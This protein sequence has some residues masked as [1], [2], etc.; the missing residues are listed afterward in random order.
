MIVSVCQTVFEMDGLPIG[1]LMSKCA[2]CI[3]LGSQ[4]RRLTCSSAI[5][6][7]EQTST[8]NALGIRP[9]VISATYD[10]VVAFFADSLPTVSH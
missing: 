8:V 6:G 3:T 7:R 1:G 2:A 10:D 5:R 9:C 4:E